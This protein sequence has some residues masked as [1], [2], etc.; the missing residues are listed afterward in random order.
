MIRAI[1]FDCFG[2]LF[3]DASQYFFEHHINEYEQLR[4]Q[5]AELFRACDRGYITQVELNEQV[6]ILTGLTRAFVDEHIQGVHQRNNTLVTFSQSLRRDYRV[7]MLSNI[8]RGSMD[9]FF[10]PAERSALFDAVVL[11][12]EEGMIKPDKEIFD[13]MAA[14]LGVLPGECVMID[15]IERNVIGAQ[16]AGMQAIHHVS[17][18]Q[19]REQLTQLLKVNNA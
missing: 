19:T 3:V 12:G 15:D 7:G 9:S 4:P 10:A 2:V 8:G 13:L 16:D 18:Q 5:I 14:R 17:N 11:S 6:A 1:I